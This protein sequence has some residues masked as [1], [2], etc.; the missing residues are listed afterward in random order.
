MQPQKVKDLVNLSSENSVTEAALI[1]ALRGLRVNLLRR[2]I[3]VFLP[4]N[5]QRETE[6]EVITKDWIRE[7]KQT[8]RWTGSGA[9]WQSRPNPQPTQ[10]EDLFKPFSIEVLLVNV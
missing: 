2:R 10:A 6:F 3:N 5:L 1:R 8:L 4:A 7:Q 9:S